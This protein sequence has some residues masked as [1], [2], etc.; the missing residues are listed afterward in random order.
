MQTWE[1][2]ERAQFGALRVVRER[3]IL[4]RVGLD[5]VGRLLDLRPWQLERCWE[6]H[7]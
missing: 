1:L 2:A 4:R 6:Q 3:D 5:A 7:V